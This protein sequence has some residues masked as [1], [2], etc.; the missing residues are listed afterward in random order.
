MKLDDIIKLAELIKLGEK[1]YERKILP[2]SLNISSRQISY[3]K[4]K[5]L[6]TFFEKEKKGYMN[7][8]EA[9]WVL[10]INDLNEIGVGTDKLEKLSIAVWKKPHKDKFADK[11]LQDEL[12]KNHPEIIKERLR[13]ILNDETFLEETLRYEINPFTNA[14]KSCLEQRNA[15]IS[16]LYSPKKNDYQIVYSNVKFTSDLNNLIYQEPLITI[17]I[18]P[19]IAKAMGVDL[20][21]TSK[22]LQYLNDIEN[23]I[24]RTIFYDKPKLIEIELNTKGET[25]IYKTTE[26]H[27]SAEELAEFIFKNNIPKDAK[28]GIEKRLQGNYKITIKS[29]SL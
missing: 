19:L 13:N 6:F 20:L 28:M 8:F 24:K 21:N 4:S 3:W 14:I 23:L 15:L 5:G 7:I 10:I 22:D 12:K 29:E 9:V 26:S 2:N 17:P 11:V 25:K 16:F 27:K 1:F 18:F